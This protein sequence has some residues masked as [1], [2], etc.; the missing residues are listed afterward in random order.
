MHLFSSIFQFFLC[1]NRSIDRLFKMGFI[2][3]DLN[4]LEPKSLQI[5]FFCVNHVQILF[6]Y[7]NLFIC[8][9]YVYCE[10]RDIYLRAIMNCE[11]MVWF[12]LFS[13][14]VLIIWFDYF[15]KLLMF[16]ITSCSW[17]VF[18]HFKVL[19]LLRFNTKNKFF[20]CWFSIL[21]CLKS[22]KRIF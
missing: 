15:S 21:M 18:F 17:F 22:W 9:G 1:Y 8:F 10:F 7:F 11:F 5:C 14:F 12:F 2:F 3:L 19:F 20:F 4:Y 16:C 13:L 6:Q